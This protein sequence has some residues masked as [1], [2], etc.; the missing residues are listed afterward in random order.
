MRRRV[1]RDLA[2][3]GLGERD[4]PAV[5]RTTVAVVAAEADV[6]AA[7]AEREARSLLDVERVLDAARGS[8]FTDILWAPVNMSRPMSWWW[9]T[10][11]A[12]WIAATTNTSC[13]AVSITGVD[14]MPSGS[15]FPHPT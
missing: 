7:V 10:L 5:V 1:E 2:G 15:M 8:A 12:S 11:K 3:A 14:V 4:E 13:R 9:I 6:D